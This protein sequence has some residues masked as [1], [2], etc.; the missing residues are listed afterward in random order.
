MGLPHEKGSSGK[1]IHQVKGLPQWVK[2]SSGKG[3][4]VLIQHALV[5]VLGKGFR[6]YH[7]G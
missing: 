4:R 5:T 6:V 2:G 3:Y 1:G 7:S